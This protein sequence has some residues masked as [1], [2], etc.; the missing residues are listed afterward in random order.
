ME[1]SDSPNNMTGMK[2]GRIDLLLYLFLPLALDEGGWSTT[3]PGHFTPW[4]GLIIPCREGWESRSG[5]MQKISPLLGFKPQ[6]VQSV[7]SRCTDY[8][9]VTAN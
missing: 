2:I 8:A 3:P 4:K 9:I 5:R 1:E 6:T 7:A